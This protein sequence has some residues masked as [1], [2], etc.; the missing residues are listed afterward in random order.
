MWPTRV[1]ASLHLPPC[2]MLQS[3]AVTSRVTSAGGSAQN[4]AMSFAPSTPGLPVGKRNSTTRRLANRLGARKVD[5]SA[6]Q[7]GS[8]APSASNTSRSAI[9][10]AR[11]A[12]RI[13]SAASSTQQRFGTGDQIGRPQ[14]LGRE[15]RR[16]PIR[17]QVHAGLPG[18]GVGGGVA[19]SVADAD[20]RIAMS[21]RRMTAATISRCSSAARISRSPPV[22]SDFVGD[23][24]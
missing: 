1:I 6:A 17:L 22:P 23:E 10:C 9:P 19:M 20:A 3:P 18:Q 11:A 7:S 13:A 4:S 5:S 2:F 12:A 16:Q 8:R 24:M 15:L 21:M 14:R